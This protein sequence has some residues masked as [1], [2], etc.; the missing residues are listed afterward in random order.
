MLKRLTEQNEELQKQLIAAQEENETLRAASVNVVRSAS[1]QEELQQMEQK[2]MQV[3]V[4]ASRENAEIFRQ[5]AQ[6]ERLKDELQQKLNPP[7][8]LGEADTR[9]RVM[10]QHLKEIHEQEKIERD[11]RKQRSLGGRIA[12]L[13]NRV[14]R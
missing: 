5:R 13:L 2:L 11:E 7:R 1:A 10:R 8:E 14:G 9:I 4:D 6:L 12:N 3:Q